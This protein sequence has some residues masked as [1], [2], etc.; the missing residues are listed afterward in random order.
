MAVVETRARSWAHLR[1]LPPSYYLWR[2]EGSPRGARYVTDSETGE[3]WRDWTLQELRARHAALGRRLG[4]VPQRPTTA[5][6]PTAAELAA[7]R[8]RHAARAARF[9]SKRRA[10]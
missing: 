3:V 6:P 4:L 5:R 10:V 7:L 2:S 9:A 1:L 8:A